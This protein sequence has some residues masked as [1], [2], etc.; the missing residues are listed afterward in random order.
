MPKDA[1]PNGGAA[2]E[3]VPMGP[4]QRV[5]EMQAKLHRW[6]AADPGRRFDDL[7]N[8]V[9]DPATLIVAFDR[10]ASNTGARTAGVDGLTVADVEQ[11]IGVPGFLDDLRAQLKTGTFRPL[12]VRERTIPKPGGSGKVRR[13]GIPTVTDRVVQAALKLVLEPIFEADFEPVSYGFRPKRR[14]H[15][16]IAE[17]HYYGTHGYRWV[18][19]ADIEACFDSISHSALMDRVRARVKDKRVLALVKAFLKAGVLLELGEQRDTPTGTPQGGILS[20]LAPWGLRL[21][22]AKTHIAH[23]SDGFDFLGFHIQWRRKRGTDKWYVYTLI[24]DRPVRQLKAKIRALT[25]RLSQQDLGSVLIR[26]NQIMR[27]WSTYFRH[28]VAKHT[29]SSLAHFVW[30]RVI[31]MLRIRHHWSWKDVRRRFTTPTGKW[32]RP[33]ANG[34][35]CSTSRRSRLP[36]TATGATRS[37][38]PGF[39][40]PPSDDRFRGEPVALR[41]ARRVRRA[42]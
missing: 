17:I 4:R 3:E 18:L 19:D 30:W 9:Y 22:R 37:P 21:S 16:A 5:S 26:L 6:A 25:R 7:V 12:P 11:R 35:G 32:L 2:L 34:V 14:A 28:T 33:A 29:F 38:S 41:G 8:F 23:M 10:V 15:D 31:R 40:R 42:A 36:A 24:A 20:L 39:C 27:G 1:P 13:L